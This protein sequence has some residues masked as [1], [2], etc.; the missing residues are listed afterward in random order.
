MAIESR[1]YPS[2]VSTLASIK[3]ALA[4]LQVNANGLTLESE[5]DALAASVGEIIEQATQLHSALK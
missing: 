1:V 4:D 3:V 2:M 5:S